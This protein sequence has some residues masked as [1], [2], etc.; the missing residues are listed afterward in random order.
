ML[1]IPHEGAEIVNLCD[2]ERNVGSDFG[3][4]N[5]S[6]LRSIKTEADLFPA[7][8]DINRHDPFTIGIAVI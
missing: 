1:E 2:A 6:S 4:G 8:S 5:S 3:G 7:W